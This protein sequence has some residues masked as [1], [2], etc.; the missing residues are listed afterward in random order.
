VKQIITSLAKKGWLKRGKLTEVVQLSQNPSYSYQDVYIIDIP[1][2]EFILEP[3]SRKEAER[4]EAEMQE[5]LEEKA[6]PF[7]EG[8]AHIIYNKEFSREQAQGLREAIEKI[9]SDMPDS[10]IKDLII[11]LALNDFSIRVKVDRNLTQSRMVTSPQE[12]ELI[13][14]KDVFYEQGK[15]EDVTLKELL[16]ELVASLILSDYPA[17]KE[18]SPSSENAFFKLELIKILLN[19]RSYL[20]LYHKLLNRYN[21]TPSKYP[22]L[23]SQQQREELLS[24][25]KADLDRFTQGMERISQ[26]NLFLNIM[27]DADPLFM[28]INYIHILLKTSA[29][30]VDI[31]DIIRRAIREPDIRDKVNI[32]HLRNVIKEFILSGKVRIK[33]GDDIQV[34]DKFTHFDNTKALAELKDTSITTENVQDF[35]VSLRKLLSYTLPL[36]EDSLNDEMARLLE[37]DLFSYPSQEREARVREVLEEFLIRRIGKRA[38]QRL[39]KHL[40]AQR[41]EEIPY[42]RVSP[43]ENIPEGTDADDYGFLEYILQQKEGTYQL[44]SQG[45]EHPSDWIHSLFYIPSDDGQ[46]SSTN[47]PSLE[48]PFQAEAGWRAGWKALAGSVAGWVGVGI[49][50]SLAGLPGLIVYGISGAGALLFSWATTRYFYLS[51]ATYKAM[52]EAGFSPDEARQKAIALSTI[53]YTQF[54]RRLKEGASQEE[55]IH[56]LTEAAKG[57]LDS[58]AIKA[59]VN[60]AIKNPR[61]ARLIMIHERF[62]THRLGMWAIFPLVNVVADLGYFRRL[63]PA[64]SILANMRDLLIPISRGT[65]PDFLG[66]DLRVEDKDADRLAEENGKEKIVFSDIQNCINLIGKTLGEHKLEFGSNGAKNGEVRR[67]LNEALEKLRKEE[68]EFRYSSGFGRY[69]NRV[70]KAV[71]LDERLKEAFQ[72]RNPNRIPRLIQLFGYIAHQAR[73]ISGVGSKEE[74]L[75]EEV[76]AGLA[77]LEI[78]ILADHWQ[79][80]RLKKL[81]ISDVGEKNL[82]NVM[83]DDILTFANMCDAGVVGFKKAEEFYHQPLIRDE[84]FSQGYFTWK[85]KGEFVTRVF[86]KCRSE[87]VPK[88]LAK[89]NNYLKQLLK[90]GKLGTAERGFAL[91]SICE[92]LTYEGYDS[93]LKEVLEQLIEETNGGNTKALEELYDAY[94]M[95]ID[96]GTA[97]I[98]GKRGSKDFPQYRYLPGPNR[99]NVDVIRRYTLALANYIKERKWQ[100]K[101]VVIGWD[102]RFGSEYFAQEVAKILR[103]EGIK[104][105]IFK[106]DRPVSEMALYVMEE[107]PALGIEITASHNEKWDNGYKISNE[108]GAQLFGVQRKE[109]LEHIA[110]V[111]MKDIKPEELKKFDLKKDRENHPTANILLGEDFD[112]KF[113][114]NIKSFILNRKLF[115]QEAGKKPAKEKGLRVFYDPFYG[116]GRFLIPKLLK[117]MGCKVKIEKEHSPMRPDGEFSKIPKNPDPAE[118]E[119]IKM[120]IKEAKNAGNNF[121]FLVATDPDSDRAAFCVRDNE[122]E[123]RYLTANQV[124]ALLIWYRLQ[125]LKALDEEGKLPREYED[126]FSSDSSIIV[127]W[128]TTDLLGEIAKDYGIRNIYRP[129]VGFSKIAEVALD[130]IVVPEFSRQFGLITD[131]LR[132]GLKKE[133]VEYLY[134]ELGGRSRAGIRDEITN[135]LRK[136]LVGGFEESNGMS[137][138]GHTLEKDGLLATVLFTELAY[139]ANSQGKTI[140]Q[141]LNEIYKRYGYYATVNIAVEPNKAEKKEIMVRVEKLCDKVKEGKRFRLADSIIIDAKD[142]NEYI[143]GPKAGEESYNRGTYNKEG[144]KLILSNGDSLIVRPSGTDRTVRFYGQC[145]VKKEELEGLDEREIERK[146][147]EADNGIKSL[148]S[149]FQELVQAEN[150]EQR[151][152]TIVYQEAEEPSLT[153]GILAFDVDGTLAVRGE[154]LPE[155]SARRLTALLKQGFKIVIITGQEFKDLKPRVVDLIPREA[156]KNLIVYCNESTQ[157]YTFDSQGRE[158]EDIAY[159][160]GFS[161]LEEKSRIEQIIKN[162]IQ[163]LKEEP[164]TPVNIRQVIQSQ[165]LE[166]IDRLTQIAFK[167][168]LDEGERKYIAEKISKKLIENHIRGFTVAVSGKTTISIYRAGVN[169]YT[170]LNNELIERRVSPEEIIFFGD[171]FGPEGNDLPVIA[172]RGITAVSVGPRDEAPASVVALEEGVQTT[173]EWLRTAL[174]WVKTSKRIYRKG[175]PSVIARMREELIEKKRSGPQEKVRSSK[176]EI[177]RDQNILKKFLDSM[178]KGNLVS[179]QAVS[180]LERQLLIPEEFIVSLAKSMPFEY[181]DA[182]TVSIERLKSQIEEA[183]ELIGEAENTGKG[184]VSIYNIQRAG[185]TE[186]MVIGEDKPGSLSRVI[187]IIKGKNNRKGISGVIKQSWQFTYGKWAV[188]VFEVVNAKTGRPFTQREINRMEWR[189]LGYELRIE[190]KEKEARNE[191][192]QF[193]KTEIGK[194]PEEIKTDLNREVQKKPGNKYLSSLIGNYPESPQGNVTFGNIGENDHR[195]INGLNALIDNLIRRGQTVQFTGNKSAEVIKERVNA[196]LTTRLKL[197]ENQKETL[198]NLNMIFLDND[199]KNLF[200]VK[201][202]YAAA[203]YGRRRKKV[204]VSKGFATRASPDEIF[205]VVSHEVLHLLGF[206]HRQATSLTPSFGAQELMNKLAKEDRL[207]LAEVGEAREVKGN[208]FWPERDFVHGKPLDPDL[209]KPTR[210]AEEARELLRKAKE[211]GIELSITGHLRGVGGPG[212]S[213]DLPEFQKLLTRPGVTRLEDLPS[214]PTIASEFKVKIRFELADDPDVIEYIAPD[215]GITEDN[216][217]QIKGEIS[218][219]PEGRTPHLQKDAPAFIFRNIFGLRGVRIICEEISPMALAGGMESSNVFN[220]ALIAAA[221]MLSGANLSYA[222]IFSLAVKLENDEFGGFTGGQGHLSCMSGGAWRH[223]WLSG[224]VREGRRYPYGAFS[225]PLLSPDQLSLVE[226]K[227]MLVQAGKEYKNGKPVEERTTV[228]SNKMWADLLRDKDEVGFSLHQEKLGLTA[229]YTQALK[230]GNFEKAVAAINRYVDIRD[231]LCLRWINLMLDAHQGKDVPDYAQGYARKVF[232]EAHPE[233]KDYKLVREMYAKH[234]EALREISLYTLDPIARVVRAARKEGIAI[235]PL[236]A[237]GPGANLIAVSSKG[238]KHLRRFFESQGLSELTEEA[239]RKIIQGTGVLKGYMPFRAGDEPLQLKGFK[240]LGLD[241]PQKASAVIYNQEDGSFTKPTNPYRRIGGAVVAWL[242]TLGAFLGVGPAAQ[243][244]TKSRADDFGLWS[245]LLHSP[246]GWI[247]GGVLVAGIGIWVIKKWGQ[248]YFSLGNRVGLRIMREVPRPGEERG[249]RFVAGIPPQEKSGEMR[250]SW[251]GPQE[252]LTEEEILR[253]RELARELREGIV[254]PQLWEKRGPWE[255]PEINLAW[256]GLPEEMAGEVREIEGFAREVRGRYESVVVIGE[257]AG[258]YAKLGANLGRKKGYPRIYVLESSHPEAIKEIG[259]KINPEKTLFIVSSLEGYEIASQLGKE[260]VAIVE[261]NTPFAREA[262]EREFVKIFNIPE[263][264]SGSYGVFSYEGLVPLALSGV[265]IEEFLESGRKGMAMCREENPEGNIGAQLAIFQEAMRRGGRN[266]IVLVLPEGLRG[267]GEWWQELISGLG[268]EGKGIIPIVEEEISSPENYGRNIAFIAI[269]VGRSPFRVTEEGTLKSAQPVLESGYPVFEISLSGKEGIG[270]LFYI[271]QFANALT[272]YLIHSGVSS[273][274]EGGVS[275]ERTENGTI[276]GARPVAGRSPFRVTEK[277]EPLAEYRVKPEAFQGKVTKV[278]AVD[279]DT[280]FDIESIKKRTPLRMD[281]EL[282]VKPKSKGVFNLMERIAS[283]A[284]E[285]GCLGRLKFA[286]VSGRR[287]VTGEVMERML[288]DYMSGYGLSPELIA[289]VIDN[290]LI[291]DERALR[292]AGGIAG[293]NSAKISAKVVFAIINERLV[294][295]TEGNGTEI[296]VITDSMDRWERDGTREMMDRMVWVVLNPA[297][298]GEVISTAGGLVVAIE[299]KVS[300]W[301]IDFIKSR[302]SE[303]EAARLLPQI[304]KDGTIILPATPVDEKYL[305]GM[306]A[307][308]R[309]YKVQA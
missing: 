164:T 197:T 166:I 97:G 219:T 137:L 203:H 210:R 249:R 282:K 22:S 208:L 278:V 110:Q 120:I 96:F 304:S 17:L 261:E 165:P 138:G 259:R 288:R 34:K 3:A 100:D 14:G 301:L 256:T 30:E 220:V 105:Y 119:N 93:E 11:N 184:Q 266:Q 267:Y 58:R 277:A 307:E 222:E 209:I 141:I 1:E 188:L 50:L 106:G 24:K 234:G 179:S 125:R 143:D 239:A 90:G 275:G 173:E 147:E 185:Y 224:I 180:E 59:F 191:L 62:D 178:E 172:I 163:R 19:Y 33:I 251:L 201:G 139:Y 56:I 218:L 28:V 114:R 242:I 4:R 250:M 53:D 86:L 146:K 285:E 287:D 123:W 102:T 177:E 262:R 202:K 79:R 306:K 73:H 107:A 5:R 57:R 76:Y 29:T 69:V 38:Y 162:V 199:G 158:I 124:W 244:A 18:A 200:W 131:E 309:I 115:A 71:Y 85:G 176:R 207:T 253:I 63:K 226:K 61:I 241:E 214:T 6:L 23:M 132:A 87:L 284:K 27:D 72:P 198:E 297:N 82:G 7:L 174:R 116:T 95:E 257:E 213:L 192:I 155:A 270:S 299:G 108:L 296:R 286:F 232:D 169:K 229:Q 182:V 111:D 13:L 254:V 9:L 136:R 134:K 292:E 140:Y 133:G 148:V 25:L 186:I 265:D 70:G 81:V 142:A 99:I 212:S 235:M 268:R 245:A 240:E 80:E 205:E 127:T 168:N 221:S 295:M 231:Q 269:G 263:G 153:R 272:G 237:G 49:S 51:R 289:S 227:M 47:P 236:G 150:F 189:K 35:Y 118:P 246:I 45:E 151:L 264:V 223:L 273:S 26:W 187:E 181:L 271:T 37:K 194:P 211:E 48:H 302:Y 303:E 247:M 54:A 10:I 238:Q 40:T 104:V 248:L 42:I 43:V 52:R 41:F 154:L 98:R 300:K 196:L 283:A 171:E 149:E 294:G 190:R 94:R 255:N 8:R 20:L 122:G 156:R 36:S 129:G 32:A 217:Y 68:V 193:C 159:R 77:E 195:R 83:I 88:K 67:I 281:I 228:R 64:A 170:S 243:A 157:R 167:Y 206:S 280:L 46:D 175:A 91:L 92:N 305:E 121:D 215:Y 161:S 21:W 44:T 12:I 216:P 75:V 39:I 84:E 183:W 230:E 66:F 31:S 128:V 113:M 126:I 290:N 233:Y 160:K 260:I 117:S 15:I 55:L 204:Y 252:G 293:I 78:Y 112:E 144:Y 103:K 152:K 308:E 89:F 101:G 258:L 276:N 225:I 135:I 65:K 145:I 274:R 279:M 130:E 109:V 60:L 16:A 2:K 298:E 74:E 291:I